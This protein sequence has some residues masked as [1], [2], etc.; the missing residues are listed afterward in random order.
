MG[1]AIA[2]VVLLLL[3]GLTALNMRFGEEKEEK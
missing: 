3:M 1:S 2:V